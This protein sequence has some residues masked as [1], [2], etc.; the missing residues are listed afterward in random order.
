MRQYQIVDFVLQIDSRRLLGPDGA[1]VELTP[2]LFDALLFMVENTGQLLDKDRLL[3]ALWPGLVVEENS[4][5]QCISGLRKA[6]GDDP[7]NP[8]FIQT[9]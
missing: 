8:R 5:S 2:R 6:L 7:Q 4:L 1:V 9:V 3:A